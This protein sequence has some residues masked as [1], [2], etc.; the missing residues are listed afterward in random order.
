L[1]D[2]AKKIQK[3]RKRAR[4]AFSTDTKIDT[5]GKVADGDGRSLQ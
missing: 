4:A 5:L 2:A 1:R 3:Q